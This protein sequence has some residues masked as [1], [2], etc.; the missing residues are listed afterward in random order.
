M[1]HSDKEPIFILLYPEALCKAEFNDSGESI[2]RQPHVQM[3][4]WILL[5]VFHQIYSEYHEQREDQKIVEN[6]QFQ[7]ENYHL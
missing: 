6:L 2:L 1:L 4:V 3:E 7:Q 5:T